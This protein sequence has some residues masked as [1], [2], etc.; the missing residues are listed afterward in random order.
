MP[1]TLA[2]R[3]TSL[4][5]CG[6]GGDNSAASSTHTIRSSGA[7]AFSIADS[8]VVLPAPVPPDTRKASLAVMILSISSAAV[9]A[10]APA[11]INAD[12]SWV[13]GRSTR[14]DRQVPPTATGGRTA[15]S[16]TAKSPLPSPVS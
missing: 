13:A 7:T 3:A 5:R 16:R 6:C 1:S 11:A 15:C 9:G 14:S 4:T 2:H 12:R 10:M 8:R